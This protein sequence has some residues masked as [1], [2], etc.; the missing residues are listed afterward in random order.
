MRLYARSELWHVLQV[1]VARLIQ[2]V[3]RGCISPQGS[4]IQDGLRPL[5]PR[6]REPSGSHGG[7][8]EEEDG[9]RGS[10][11]DGLEF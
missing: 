7:E 10:R 2:A 11:D 8:V 6:W 9:E 3:D 4:P 1:D 5:E